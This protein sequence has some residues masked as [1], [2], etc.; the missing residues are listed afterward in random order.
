M[1]T[2]MQEKFL[3]SIEDEATRFEL[4]FVMDKAWRQNVSNLCLQVGY[5]N[6]DASVWV[7]SLDAMESRAAQAEENI[8]KAR[9]ARMG[10]MT[11][12]TSMLPDHVPAVAQVLCPIPSARNFSVNSMNGIQTR[13]R[14]DSCASAAE[15]LE[16]SHISND[17]DRGHF[18]SSSFEDFTNIFHR[19][20]GESTDSVNLRKAAKL[21]NSSGSFLDEVLAYIQ[22]Q[23]LPFQHVD[24]WV[25]SHRPDHVQESKSDA[26]DVCKCLLHSG[27]GTRCDL[28]PTLFQQFH[29]FGDYSANFSFS[30]GVGLPGRVF[31]S[32]KPSWECRL[33]QSDVEHFPRSDIAK[34]YAIKTG[35][36][37]PL[38][39]ESFG[40]IV[41][42]LYSVQDIPEDPKKVEKWMSD[43][44]RFGPRPQWKLV[45]EAGYQAL[46]PRFDGTCKSDQNPYKPG[47]VQD[48]GYSSISFTDSVSSQ[49]VA[50]KKRAMSQDN[51]ISETISRSVSNSSV[52]TRDHSNTE[53]V[54]D[55]EIAM[56]KLLGDHMPPWEVSISAPSVSPH[57]YMTLRLLLLRSPDDRSREENELIDLIRKGYNGYVQD[58]TRSSTEI[59]QLLVKDWFGLKLAAASTPAK[60]DTATK[61]K[62]SEVALPPSHSLVGW[63]SSTGTVLPCL[64][65]VL[66][67]SSRNAHLFSDVYGDHK[68][69]RLLDDLTD[70]INIVDENESSDLIF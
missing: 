12:S 22:T 42:I 18:K 49:N 27:H 26:E 52:S 41:V 43:F 2:T 9:R 48:L 39:T 1:M 17:A 20:Q 23:N 5:P 35:L 55:Q 34:I 16:R 13:D 57:Y 28:D 19:L 32:G 25:P 53:T 44:S 29:Q 59:A 64:A 47:I 7:A 56:A 30:P 51:A 46:A 68:K 40:C 45:V 14:Q 58:K 4:R 66:P 15:A 33:D 37:I 61:S 24:V 62:G 63:F 36:G 31:Q 3:L 70:A 60:H 10:L 69:R 50:T 8:R 38:D 11:T 65:P 6:L 67:A 21:R 54:R